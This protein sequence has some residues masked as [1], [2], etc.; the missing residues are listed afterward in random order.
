MNILK[1]TYEERGKYLL[2]MQ[3]LIIPF[4]S[5]PVLITIT[6]HSEGAVII[7]RVWFYMS[8]FCH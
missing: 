7:W 6:T 1:N 3:H 5:E 8:D 2:T 4:Q